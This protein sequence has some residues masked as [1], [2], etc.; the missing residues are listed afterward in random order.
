MDFNLP[1]P[2][3]SRF[4]AEYTDSFKII[5]YQCCHMVRNDSCDQCKTSKGKEF[6]FTFYS[7]ENCQMHEVTSG[8]IYLS[9][10]S[11]RNWTGDRHFP[12]LVLKIGN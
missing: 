7:A 2:N 6:R 4:R 10:K 11:L 12:L 1:H 5:I 9:W 3:T 8:L